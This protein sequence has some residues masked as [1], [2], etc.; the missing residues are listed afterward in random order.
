VPC[1]ASQKR[2]MDG[3]VTARPAQ[4]RGRM[5]GYSSL[6]LGLLVLLALQGI[7]AA[8]SNPVIFPGTFSST[9]NMNEG[10]AGHTATV[11]LSGQVLVA[12]GSDGSESLSTAEAYDPSSGTFTEIGSMTTARDSQ[13]ATLLEDGRVLITG[14]FNTNVPLASAEL[15]DPGTST[16]SPTGDMGVP[17]AWH[18]ATLLK[19]GEVLVTGG[20]NYQNGNIAVL[21]SAEIYDPAIGSFSPVGD[22]TTERT[23]HT[24][25]LLAGGQVLI[26]G[27][28]TTANQG[29]SLSS[30]EIYEPVAKS[31]TPIANMAV[32]RCDHTATLLKNGQVLLAGGFDFHNGQ[33]QATAS[34]ELYYPGSKSFRLTGPMHDKRY[35]Q[36]ATLLDNGRVL[37]SGGT[38]QSA[39]LYKN[40]TKKFTTTGSMETE[41]RAHTATLLNDGRVLVAG[42]FGNFYDTPVTA[43]LY[44]P[45]GG[46]ISVQP[47]RI[48]FLPLHLNS[49]ALTRKIRLT[50]LGSKVLI[51]GVAG[52]AAP[53]LVA[54]GGGWFKLARGQKHGVSI[55]FTPNELGRS[56]TQLVI[57]TSD[58]KHPQVKITIIGSVN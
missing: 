44:L 35:L 38:V 42:G 5:R 50:N 48:A 28:F 47:K 14:G 25:T 9:G 46:S 1:V 49:S 27:G 26:A 15:F 12:G 32:A 41:R 20:L 18:A 52:L 10:R 58:P 56:E 23:Q 13:T 8:Q 7:P 53:F 45:I 24:A 39:E 17:R 43:E 36:T 37:I 33:G 54:Q 16:F 34:A 3:S 40:S 6:S 2:V 57:T 55:Q 19:N 51:L 4:S 30:A 11:L 31:F 29:N 21:S 22:M